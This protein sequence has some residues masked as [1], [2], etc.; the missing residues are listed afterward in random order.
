MIKES[1]V[2]FEVAKLLKEKFFDGEFNTHMFYSEFDE[3]IHPIMEIGLVKDEGV[4]FAPTY[5]MA[6]AWLREKNIRIYIEPCENSKGLL[7]FRC[8]IYKKVDHTFSLSYV[9]TD[10]E[11]FEGAVKVALKYSLENLI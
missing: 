4:Y 9:T 6:L 11:T 7:A 8:S 2:S 5:Q 1:Y 10:F 3:T